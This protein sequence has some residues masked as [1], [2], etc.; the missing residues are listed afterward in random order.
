MRGMQSRSL[1]GP[2]DARGAYVPLSLSRSQCEGADRRF[3][4]LIGPRAMAYRLIQQPQFRENGHAGRLEHQAG[5][6]GTRRIEPF[7]QRHLMPGAMQKERS[8]HA[9]RVA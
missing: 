3:W 9:A 1:C 6:D 4:C 2:V 7:E 8:R 5:A